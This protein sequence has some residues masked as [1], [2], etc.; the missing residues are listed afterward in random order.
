L[1]SPQDDQLLASFAASKDWAAQSA[2]YLASPATNA[3]VRAVG[4]LG[5]LPLFVISATE[6]GTPPDLEQL[7]QGWQEE[8]ASLSTNSRHR[9]VDGA[10]HTSL[11]FDAQD[12]QASIAAIEEIVAAARTGQP[13]H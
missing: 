2:E 11:V 8:M 10:G 13:L 4:T 3:Q 6:H 12:A 1:P 9:V 7:W 5:D